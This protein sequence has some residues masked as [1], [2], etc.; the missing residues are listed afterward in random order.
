AHIDRILLA[1]IAF[2]FLAF[3]IIYPIGMVLALSCS[4]WHVPV[5]IIGSIFTTIGYFLGH[6]HNGREFPSDNIYSLF[7]PFLIYALMCQVGIGA[8]LKLHLMSGP[9]KWFQP[10]FTKVIKLL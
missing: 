7:A 6:G 9:N 10:L 4:C 3:G 2:M 1:H 8:Y 5:Q